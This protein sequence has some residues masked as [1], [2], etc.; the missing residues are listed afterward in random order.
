MP[1]GRGRK[2]RPAFSC[3]RNERRSTRQD[4]R[5]RRWRFASPLRGTNALYLLPQ[6]SATQIPGGSLRQHELHFFCTALRRSLRD[7]AMPWLETDPMIVRKKFVQDALS[8]H[9]GG[10]PPYE[11]GERSILH[12]MVDHGSCAPRILLARRVQS[13]CVAILSVGVGSIAPTADLL[14]PP[15]RVRIRQPA[16]RDTMAG[17]AS[18]NRYVPDTVS[19]A[20]LA[21]IEP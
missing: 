6:V 20:R 5:A 8:D 11:I 1:T 19:G 12:V 9:D 10:C 15:S 16:L 2:S 18:H 14:P 4:R 17:R 21:L 7:V 13:A 3:H